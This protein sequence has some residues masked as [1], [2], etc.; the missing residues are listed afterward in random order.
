MSI[1]DPVAVIW[2]TDSVIEMEHGSLIAFL[3][4][5]LSPEQ[6]GDEVA[7]EVTACNLACSQKGEGRILLTSGPD[8]IVTRDHARRLLE[9]V[10]DRRLTLEIANYTA[11]CIIH[12]D[13]EFGDD[14]VCEAIWL[15]EM[16]DIDQPTSDDMRTAIARLMR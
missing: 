1:N 14:I 16:A 2:R 7:G 12:G 4:G 8:T 9:A 5:K 11:S 6:F 3:E 10:E 15:V 13:F